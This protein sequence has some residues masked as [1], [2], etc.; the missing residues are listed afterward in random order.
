MPKFVIFFAEISIKTSSGKVVARSATY[1]ERYQHSAGDDP[2][3]VKFG[4]KSTD[5]Q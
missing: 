2:V 5:H 4:P 1:I 3:P